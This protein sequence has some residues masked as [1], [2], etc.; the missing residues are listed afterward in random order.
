M[1]LSTFFEIRET[2]GDCITDI[3]V[4][5]AAREIA[6][7]FAEGDS[8]KLDRIADLMFKYSSI[9][10]STTATKMAH[11]LMGDEFDIMAQEAMEMEDM[12]NQVRNEGE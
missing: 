3:E 4:M 10:A 1:S 8:S 7:E 2:V 5:T 11:L 6:W 9:L 12:F